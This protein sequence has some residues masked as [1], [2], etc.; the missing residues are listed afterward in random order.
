M[1][2]ELRTSEHRLGVPD[3]EEVEDYSRRE[4]DWRPDGE[5]LSLILKSDAGRDENDTDSSDDS[6]DDS[7]SWEDSGDEE[8]TDRVIL[9]TSPFGDEDQTIVYETES[10]MD[11][12]MHN[13]DASVLFITERSSGDE[14]LYTEFMD[15]PDSKYTI[16][17]YDR[18]EFYEDPVN[19]MRTIGDL[20][21]D[22]VRMLPDV[23]KVY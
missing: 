11:D 17:D 5:G 7:E 23:D 18:S 4:I 22:V 9:W 15:E 14:E 1:L 16:Y 6:T 19:V 12:V 21:E 2:T 10:E 13:N 8:V 3:S 20:G